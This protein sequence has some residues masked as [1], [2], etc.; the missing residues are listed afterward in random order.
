MNSSRRDVLA[1]LLA[2]AAAGQANAT[3]APAGAPDVIYHNGVIATLD[4][5]RPAASAVAVKDGLFQAIG[6]SSD[7]LRLAGSGTRIV[8]L[9]G[10]FVVP[11]LIDAHTHPAE[12]LIMKQSWVDA[13][14]PGTP[15]VKQALANIAARV[16]TTPKGEWIFVACVSASQNKFAEKR[17][18][19]KAEL[20]AVAPDNPV[21]VANGTHMGVANSA[22]LEAIGVT[23][24]KL[25][26]KGG[27]QALAGPDGEPDGTMTDPF[28][29]LPNVVTAKDFVTNYLEGIPALWNANGF[30]SV[31]A[32]T[33]AEA[34]PALK[35]AAR[36]PDPKIR[37]TVSVWTSPNSEDMPDD[38]GA[39]AM[40]ADVDPAFHRFFGI[41]TWAD[42]ENDARTGLMYE[43]YEGHFESDP[44]GCKG[45]LVTPPEAMQRFVGIA[46]RNGAAAMIH[47]SGDRATDMGLNAYERRVASGAPDTI[48]R[49]EHFGVFQ[50]APRQLERAAALRKHK[51]FVSVQPVWL[52]DLARED[53]ENMGAPLARTGFEFRKL[54][55]AGLEPA[56]GTDVT[57]IYLAN[58]NPFLGIY[59]AVTRDSDMGTFEPQEA[60]TVEEALKMWTLWAARSMGE[61][62]VK[63]SIEP[64]K[65]ADLT[66]LS[67]DIFAIPKAKLKDVKPVQTI[68][69]G[70]VV[71]DAA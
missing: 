51:L 40:P 48:M 3:P 64:G 52:L 61:E 47:C 38:L 14:Y 41:K 44:P 66:V 37:Y 17:L 26:L 21:F 6:Q 20:D 19:T 28:G 25:A 24:G 55:D 9:G 63:G 30:T 60:V 59:A 65:Y 68:V 45:S 31:L 43:C 57:G 4:P 46:N 29:A 58:V 35:V 22:A 56:G 53:V 16:R 49:I 2:T 42:G 71:Y 54:I 62:A 10:R 70:R 8:D 7:I 27:G 34:L 11:G 36:T 33:P 67:D 5:A 15:S 23:R 1:G 18:P 39:F 69:G 32:I 50:L 12:T 13:R